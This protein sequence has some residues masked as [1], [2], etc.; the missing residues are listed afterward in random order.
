MVAMV[1]AQAFWVGVAGVC[2]ALP[3]VIVLGQLAD[4]M[5]AKVLLPAWLLG[6]T[7]AITLFMAMASGLAALRSLGL[8]DPATLLR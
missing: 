3:A 1:L 8:V 6:G 4:E 5:G 2:L 7:V